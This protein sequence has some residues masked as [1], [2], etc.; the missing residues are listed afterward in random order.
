M[1]ARRH[2]SVVPAKAGTHF[3]LARRSKMNPGFAGDDGKDEE[4]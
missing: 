2:I 1:S 3:A 4:L